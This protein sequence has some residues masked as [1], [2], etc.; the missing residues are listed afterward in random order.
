M[1]A[2][3]LTNRYQMNDQQCRIISHKKG[4][5]LVIAGPGSGKT[6][7]L[8]LL[9]MNLLLCGDAQPSQLVLCTYTEKAAYEMHDRIASIAR[10]IGYD[11]DLSELKI[12]TIHGICNQFIIENLHHTPLGNNYETLDQFTQ[13]LLL[14]EYIDEICPPQMRSFFQHYWKT[15]AT[16]EIAKKFQF[17]FDKIAEE[18]IFEK[19]K[20]SLAEIK[21]YRSDSDK[22][23][24]YLTHAYKSYQMILAKTNRI[25]FAHL[26]KCAY[27]LL[28]RPDTRHSITKGIRYV[29]VD[30]YQDTN[31]IQERILTLLA[32]AT[33]DRNICVVGDEDQALYRFRGATVRNILEFADT[34]PQCKTVHL[35]TNYRSHPGIIN[36]CNRWITSIDWSN[37]EGTSFRAE[38]TIRPSFERN[39]QEYPSVLSIGDVDVVAE[40]EQFADIVFSLK[41]Q[42][43]I[44]DYSQVALLL[45]SVRSGISDVFIEALKSK[46]IPAFCP[47]AR[48]YFDQ[49]EICLMMGCLARIVGYQET[50]QDGLVEHSGLP[51]YLRNCHM[52]LAKQCQLLPALEQKLQEIESEI[53]HAEEDRQ[54]AGK[55]LADYFYHLVFTEPFMSLLSSIDRLHNL[56]LFS[57]FLQI[58]QNYY[59]V[60]ITPYHLPQVE[61]DLFHRFFCLLYE[62]GVNQYEDLQMPLQQGYVQVMTIHQAKGLEFPVVVVGRLDKLPLGTTNEDRDLQ[63]FYH[64]LPFEP[65]Q[66]IAGFDLRRLYYVAFSRA[67]NLLILTAN[68]KPHAQFA[69]LW[70]EISAW[71]YAYNSSLQSMPPSKLEPHTPL[72][73]RY[74]FTNHIRMYE[75]CPRQFQYFRE[76]KFAST[77]SLEVFSGLL[78]HQTLEGIHQI[79]LGGNI[80]TLND[81]KVQAIF[82]R[83]LHFLKC[84]STFSMDVGEQEKALRQVLNYFHNNYLEL[85]RIAATELSIQVEQDDYILTGKIDLVM[86]GNEG[87][88]IIDFKTRARPED[89]SDHLVF[90]KRQLYLYAYGL[91]KRMKELPKRLLLYWTA[92][93]RKE[94]ALMEIPYSDEDVKQVRI[95]FDEFV[96][97]IKQHQFDVI[98]PPQ[99]E[100]CGSCNIR[101]L[102]IKE[103][104]I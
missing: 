49:E 10:D 12:N 68:K 2:P 28:E 8:V 31:Y 90:Y 27:N 35:I 86:K 51:E 60:N 37:P 30:E 23:L 11:E 73:S 45:Y 54:L 16:G 32:S 44:S 69:S 52:L 18:L 40:A 96:G 47:R 55:Q 58:F 72:K 99:P 46:G 75:T 67:Q 17:F 26:Q 104:I 77:R 94:D 59:H 3:E 83:T 5:L 43:R 97:K 64:R 9:A 93:E 88:E 53:A 80:D 41:E 63:P 56:S 66:R 95:Y 71:Q 6:H 100:I 25:D 21:S 84:S 15:Q 85:H 78:I 33:D 57:H 4:P 7:S 102:C 79:A 92:E 39:D 1:I 20:R 74:S 42:Q 14:V 91:E 48:T 81:Q 34:F 70:K 61:F 82:E 103:G 24:Y 87:L 89:N 62:D 38:K 29:L 13:R 101:H 98:I 65:V 50:K 22:F 19:L 76:H 36:V